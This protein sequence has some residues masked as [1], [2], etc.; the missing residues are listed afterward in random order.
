MPSK[1]H[2]KSEF[3]IDDVIVVDPIRPSKSKHKGRTAVIKHVGERRLTVKFDDSKPG[4]YVDFC[5]AKKIEETAE[6]FLRKIDETTDSLKQL[7]LSLKLL[8]FICFSG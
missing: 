7:I 6:E 3:D 4:T 2:K 8:T 5:D 1:W